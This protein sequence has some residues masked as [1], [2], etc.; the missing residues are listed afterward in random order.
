MKAHRFLIT[1]LALLVAGIYLFATAPAPLVEEVAAGKR[2]PIEEVLAILNHENQMVRE[3]YTGQIVLRG[4]KAGLKFDEN[5][6]DEGFDAG[7]LPAQFLRL[8]AVSLE[9]SRM[10]LGLF[11]GSDYPINKANKFSGLQ[12]SMFR[13]LRSDGRP[14]HFYMRDVG[15]HAYMYADMAISKACVECHNEHDETPKEDWKLNDVMGATTWTYPAGAVTFSEFFE[16]LH[17]LRQAF[18][19]AYE[20]YL[21]KIRLA[22]RPPEIGDKWPREGYYLPSVEV[23]MEEIERRCSPATLESLLTI[24][25]EERFHEAQQSPG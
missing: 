22:A 17:T 11:L 6:R 23:F 15:L 4:T 21:E 25:R 24:T 14:R 3:I 10:R 13:E 12:L 18:K 20:T 8:T 7:P 9:K 2:I 5:W 16:L 19:D 1:V